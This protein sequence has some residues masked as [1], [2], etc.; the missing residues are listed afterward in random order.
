ME[1]N[2]ASSVLSVHN[3]DILPAIV[4][5]EIPIEMDEFIT[6]AEFI[7]VTVIVEDT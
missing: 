1:E 5:K 7:Q 6:R 2:V 3:M 4:L